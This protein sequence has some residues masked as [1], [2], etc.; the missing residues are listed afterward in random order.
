VDDIATVPAGEYE[1]SDVSYPEAI[2]I[3]YPIAKAKINIFIDIILIIQKIILYIQL[4]T[5]ITLFIIHRFKYKPRLRLL[6]MVQCFIYVN[7]I[8]NTINYLLHSLHE[9]YKIQP[10]LFLHDIY[11]LLNYT[12]HPIHDSNPT[13]I[14]YYID[15]IQIQ[16]MEMSLLLDS[17]P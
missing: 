13:L 2:V 7:L 11:L 8:S 15:P 16:L 5:P 1:V 9:S 17:S 14:I 10:L 3:K 4:N 12:L 6:I